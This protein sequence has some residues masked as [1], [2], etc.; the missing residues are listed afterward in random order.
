MTI[1]FNYRIG[2]A[3]IWSMVVLGQTL[4]FAPNYN[5]GKVAGGRILK[6]LATRPEIDCSHG[7]GLQI[8]RMVPDH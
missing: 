5:K 7:V 4:A 3:L 8:V 1:V 6:L 2:E